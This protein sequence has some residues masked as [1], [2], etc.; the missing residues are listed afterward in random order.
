MKKILFAVV[1]I[2]LS[3]GVFGL[4]VETEAVNNVVIP[5][6]NQPAKF[7]F[8][9]SNITLPG[10]YN[11]YSL[12]NLKMLPSNEFY[13][14]T[15]PEKQNLEVFF[16]PTD[17]LDIEGFYTFVYYVNG[18]EKYED[19]ITLKI[20]NLQDAIEI[21]SE[22]ND[23]D[24]GK[25]NFY[26][27]NKEN[28]DLKGLKAKFSSIFFDDVE[29]EFDLPANGIADFEVD[30]D[31][32][33][34]KTINAGSYIVKADFDV[35][36]GDSVVE[37]KIYLGKKE[38]IKKEESS[39]GFFINTKTITSINVGNVEQVVR[40][41]V[42]KDIFTRLFTS[43]NYEPNVVKRDGFTVSYLW[44]E[45]LKPSEVYSIKV[46]TN[47]LFP[48]LVIIVAGLIII[49]FKHY[50]ESKIIVNKTVS[51]VKTKK[52]F[53]L[54]V[55]INVKARKGVANVSIIDKI[56]S[57]VKVYNKFGSI[58]PSAYD[59]KNR[60]LEW[61]LGTLNAGEERIFDYI[62]YSKLGVVGKFSLPPANA[63][64]EFNGQVHETESNEV[65]FLSEQ[66]EREED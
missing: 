8:I 37:G 58:K 62:I 24:S 1:F 23:F 2:M 31:K 59:V 4:N 16:Y 56:P 9:F 3:S 26:I 6:F 50:T 11:V 25:I 64:F 19:K 42:K 51:P 65:F 49:G 39:S 12:S 53:A 66:I 28:I 20:V 43:F 10:K 35:Q 63:I 22:E 18:E 45:D 29:R 21:S 40:V 33:R 47:Y 57:I 52:G 30:V 60:R 46:K 14:S 44:I 54:K 15:K 48:F 55:R 32:E 61:D 27:K 34:I 7:N 36:R 13:L 17:Q 38:G 5:Q 41:E